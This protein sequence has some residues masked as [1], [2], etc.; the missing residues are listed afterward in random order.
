RYKQ[1]VAAWQELS[2]QIEQAPAG[3]GSSRAEPERPASA[4]HWQQAV[5]QAQKLA[6]MEAETLRW[7]AS[8]LA[9]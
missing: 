5:E 9:E 4:Q 6:R 8:S 7:L 1:I 3:T 2:Q